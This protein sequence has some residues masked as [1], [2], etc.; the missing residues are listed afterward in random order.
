[1]NWFLDSSR[2]L[3]QSQCHSNS[4]FRW[5]VSHW[6]KNLKNAV[7]VQHWELFKNI[8]DKSQVP[9]D[10][11][12]SN[13][14]VSEIPYK[15]H[16][17]T[18]YFIIVKSFHSFSKC[19]KIRDL[20]LWYTVWKFKNFSATQILREISFWQISDS[21]SCKNSSNSKFNA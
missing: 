4:E 15:V 20:W 10:R 8:L 14:A 2:M 7:S 11:N 21:K 16:I 6:A 9:R 13:D 12:R 1:M 18:E 5:S 3:E 17:F 19:R